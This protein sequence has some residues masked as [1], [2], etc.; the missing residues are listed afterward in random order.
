MIKRRLPMNDMAPPIS[1]TDVAT[2]DLHRE[3]IKRDGVT[4]VFLGPK[5][6]ITKTV[7]G[8]AWVVVNRD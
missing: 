2:V 5:D 8:P 1:L 7:R 6:E 3:I 4:A